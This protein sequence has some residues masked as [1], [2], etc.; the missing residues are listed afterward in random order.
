VCR[1]ID[2]QLLDNQKQRTAILNALSRFRCSMTRR[3]LVTVKRVID[4]VA[5][6]RRIV[7]HG[8]STFHTDHPEG[9]R[10]R[11]RGLGR[12][13]AAR[14]FHPP[15]ST[16]VDLVLEAA[17]LLLLLAVGVRAVLIMRPRTP[18]GRRS[19]TEE[20]SGSTDAFASREFLRAALI[21]S[22]RNPIFETCSA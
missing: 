14:R 3:E 9:R 18:L 16:G 4:E 5:R 8:P 17:I 11:A 6:A 7:W 1:S 2:P 12:P 22:R 15:G 20:F 13:L 10:T 21:V 19:T